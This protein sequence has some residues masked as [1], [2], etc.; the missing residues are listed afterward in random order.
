MKW[1]MFFN[2][3]KLKQLLYLLFGIKWLI[4]K[5]FVISALVLYLNAYC[6]RGITKV[7]LYGK[8]E[9]FNLLNILH[10]SDD[11]ECGGREEKSA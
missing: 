8:L 7:Q 1:I 2:F 3:K 9:K 5:V 11:V 10:N 6:D 4:P